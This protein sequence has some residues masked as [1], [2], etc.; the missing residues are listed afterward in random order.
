VVRHS[1]LPTA[2]LAIRK[3]AAIEALARHGAA[4]PEW[5]A[6]IPL[7][8]EM[9]PTSALL[10]WLGI[11][12]RMPQLPERGA[13]RAEALRILRARL[14]LNG[15]R[16]AFSAEHTDALWWLMLSADA[17]AVRLIPALLDEPGWREELP[18]I[19]QGALARQQRGHWSTTTANAWGVLAFEKFSEAFEK[20]PVAGES[21]ASLAGESRALA[22]AA[23]PDGGVLALPWPAGP[24]TLRVTQAGSGRPWAFVAARA[25]LPLAEPLAAGFRIRRSVT[26]VEARTPGRVSRGDTA[27]VTLAIDAQSDMTWV[28]VDDPIPAGARILG[29]GLRGSSGLLREGERSEGD[30][31][32]AFEERRFEGLRAYYRFVP[33][34]RF[35]LEY[36]VRYDA[37]GRFE[38]PPTRVEALYAPE[39]FGALPNAPVAVEAAP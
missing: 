39:M 35:T 10:D 19:A 7:E 24:G 31:W 28:V 4:R 20:T 29:G 12:A 27:R 21:R 34:G 23:G 25:A 11:L 3:L 14:D 8:P 30:A 6:S 38:L 36:S 22:W 33:K 18:R 15:T 37:P 16:L 13:R 2:D 17:N 32:P 9:W 26:P 1:A 5:L